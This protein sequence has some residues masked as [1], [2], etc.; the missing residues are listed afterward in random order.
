MNDTL[1]TTTPCASV[2][3]WREQDGRTVLLAGRRKG[4]QA[5]H[6][7]PLPRTSPLAADSEIVALQGTPTLFSFTV[8]H[9]SPKAGL[10]PVTLGY[11]DF[12]EG[13]R[14]FGRLIYP[15]DRRPLIGEPLRAC[16][17][18]APDGDIYAFEPVASGN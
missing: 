6:F 15:A 13:V 8:M 17:V 2:Q 18:P 5:L 9:H 1:Q 4:K 3:P 11:A 16:L 14:I 7:P 12:P 10:P